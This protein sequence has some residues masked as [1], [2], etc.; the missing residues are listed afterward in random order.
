MT[1]S[2]FDAFSS[3]TMRSGPDANDIVGMEHLGANDAGFVD[4]RSISASQIAD[5]PIRVIA[6]KREMLAG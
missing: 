2:T 6:L 4:E 5:Q 3:N 1:L